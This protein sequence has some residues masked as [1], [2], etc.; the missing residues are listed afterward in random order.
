M[1]LDCSTATLRFH[2][3]SATIRCRAH[4]RSVGHACV[5]DAC[6]DCGRSARAAPA[7]R[8]SQTEG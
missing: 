8:S 3:A 4:H 6:R 1:T 7:G 2:R 5:S